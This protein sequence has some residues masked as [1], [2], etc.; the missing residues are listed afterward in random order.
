MNFFRIKKRAKF[1]ERLLYDIYKLRRCDCLLI[2]GDSDRGNIRDKKPFS[3]LIDPIQEEL[4]S[5]EINS[6][7]IAKNGS[8][9]TYNSAW[10]EPRSIDAIIQFADLIS[11][12]LKKIRFPIID[13]LGYRVV[14]FLTKPKFIIVIGATYELCSISRKLSVP[15]LEILHGIGYKTIPIEWENICEDKLPSHILSLDRV[16][17]NSLRDL[18]DKGV[19]IVEIPHPWYKNI[20]IP[21]SEFYNDELDQD[22][23]FIPPDK[24]SV[25]L[26]LNW[27]YDN[28]HSSY[29]C[30]KDVLTNGLI[31]EVIYD[32]ILETSESIFWSIRRHPVQMRN[33]KYDHQID[34]LNELVQSQSNCEWE[35][36]SEI[37]LSALSKSIDAHITMIS[38]TSYDMAIYG[39]KSLLLCPT[40]LNNGIYSAMFEDL[41]ESGYA[42]KIYYNEKEAIRNWI[43][44]VKRTKQYSL[45]KSTQEDWE[46]LI[47][48]LAR[49]TTVKSIF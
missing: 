38:M 33:Q 4:I 44:N 7:Q 49:K 46:K 35:K 14:F 45:S 30:F 9:L 22:L 26:S 47:V 1:T 24:K 3:K 11:R 28:D 5:L 19:N 18:E 2:C 43:K 8:N 36:S 48:S 6:L 21:Y 12:F 29:K 40:L 13:N 15:L 17:T 23:S 34:F 16:S 41:V 42:E 37:S 39:I 27:G 31:P 25:L 10:G 32:L 20:N